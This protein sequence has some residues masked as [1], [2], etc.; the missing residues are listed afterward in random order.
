MMTTIT[1]TAI[2]TSA[3]LACDPSFLRHRFALTTQGMTQRSS[4][5]RWQPA[6][7]IVLTHVL[8]E[9]DDRFYGAPSVNGFDKSGGSTSLRAPI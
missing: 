9:F 8:G 6:A 5:I 7:E 3:A 4:E 1:M 2:P